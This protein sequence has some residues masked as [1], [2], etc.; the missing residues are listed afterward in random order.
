MSVWI[1]ADLHVHT[2]LSPCG[3]REMRPPAILLH[4]ERLGLGVV[5]VVDHSSARNAAAVLEAAQAFAVR[6]FVGLEVESSEGV[7]ILA[8]FDTAE[9]AMDMDRL[10]A[11][12]LPD[13]PNR[14]DL[15][16]EQWLVNEWGDVIGC[17]ERLLVAATDLSI[18][19]IVAQTI[20]RGG[21]SI[22]AHIDR[23]ANGLL[24]VLGFVPPTLQVDAFE[25]SRHLPVTEARRRWATL[26]GRPLLCSSDA[27][28][29]G[30]MGQAT[31]LIPQDL[32]TAGVEA[33]EW[34]RLLGKWLLEG[35]ETH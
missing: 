23:T 31:T 32:V 20:A 21:I 35:G 28:Y 7:H 22:P 33:R 30:D 2:V 25:L 5:G 15:F 6:V 27:H 8:L 18:E 10:V 13:L 17:D 3:G 19:Q 9:A 11:E 24:P 34:I 14:P 12:H 29:M 26:K 16:G 4:A 1:P